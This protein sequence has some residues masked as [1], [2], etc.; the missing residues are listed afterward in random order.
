MW[1]ETNMS[2]RGQR[3]GASQMERDWHSRKETGKKELTLRSESSLILGP[4]VGWEY[5]VYWCLVHPCVLWSTN[6]HSRYMAINLTARGRPLIMQICHSARQ[7]RWWKNK[8]D[9]ANC[10]TYYTLANAILF[11]WRLDFY[12]RF[13]S[14]STEIKWPTSSDYEPRS[15]GVENLDRFSTLKIYIYEVV[16]ILITLK[17]REDRNRWSV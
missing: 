1:N 9:Q 15:D 16:I 3:Y 12:L 14:S 2:R 11:R 10:Y 7:S 6:I 13:Q 4:S 8:H 5:Y 17:R